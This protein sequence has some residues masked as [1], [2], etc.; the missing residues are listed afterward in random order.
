MTSGV[1][2]DLAGQMFGR[3]LVLAKSSSRKTPNGSIKPYWK[4]L[5]SCGTEIEVR[6][7]SLRNGYSQSRGCLAKEMSS[8]KHSTHGQSASPTYNTWR[9][10]IERCN[11]KGN[12][13]YKHYGERGITVCKEW[14]KYENFLRDMGIRPE[15][16]SIERINN[17]LGYNKENC[18]WATTQEQSKNTTKSVL[19]EWGGVVRNRCDWAKI[20]GITPGALTF[21]LREWGL[22][23]AM[24][25]PSQRKAGKKEQ[26]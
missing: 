2:I 18:K 9:A 7:E 26:E 1:K 11:R 17:N 21:R 22:E 19:I 4:C 20:M 16:L 8:A 10:M 14:L 3:L 12:S 25:T 6:A 15:G 24:T 5:C 13:R 23:R